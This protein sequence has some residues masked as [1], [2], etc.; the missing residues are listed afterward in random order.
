MRSHSL[1]LVSSSLTRFGA[2]YS[3]SSYVEKHTKVRGEPIPAEAASNSPGIQALAARL[4]LKNVPATTLARSLIDSTSSL[5]Y[6]NNA[7]LAKFGK[8]L[9]SFYVSEHFMTKYPRLPSQVLKH[10]V[11]SYTGMAALSELGQM[12][13]VQPDT[14]SALDRYLSSNS[15]EQ[16]LGRL[17]FSD[18]QETVE[19]GVTVVDQAGV[20]ST[21]LRN[22]MGAFVRSLV[23]SV[24]AHNGIGAAQEFINDY[25]VAP[26]KLDVSKLMLF[27]RPTRELAV[28]CAREGLEPPVSRLIAESGR[29]SNQA[30]FVVGVF[31]GSSKIGEGQGTSLREARTRASVN[32]LQGWYLYSPSSAV[33]E[34]AKSENRAAYID[35]GEIVI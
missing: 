24:Y 3:T 27:S 33:M 15:D 34:K 29:Y 5:K 4:N 35:A 32:A 13:G 20:D 19:S 17:S 18:K 28:L 12:W 22:A 23:T 26:R 10:L 14:R 21:D 2:Q 8:T 16:V 6:V 1:F 30:V 25:I 9:L 31:S 7:G 11:D